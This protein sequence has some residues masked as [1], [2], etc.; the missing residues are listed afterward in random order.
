MIHQGP[1]LEQ[2][3]VNMHLQ[4]RRHPV[5]LVCDKAE[6]YLRFGIHPDD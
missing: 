1:K 5:V 2:D 3:L 6:T 4:F